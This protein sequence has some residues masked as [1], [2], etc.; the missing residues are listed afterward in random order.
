M[1]ISS[2]GDDEIR[3][4]VIAARGAGTNFFD[5]ADT[6]GTEPHGCESRFGSAVTFSPTERESITIQSKVVLGTT[7]FEH[8]RDSAAGS[9]IPL[10]WEEWYRL[11]TAAGQII[12]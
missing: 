11:F 1:R 2:L 8:L 3:A 7:N 12:P 4:L 10:T 9:D 6:Y 5:H